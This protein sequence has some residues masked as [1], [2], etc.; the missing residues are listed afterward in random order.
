MLVGKDTFVMGSEPS[1]DLTADIVEKSIRLIVLYCWMWFRK[2]CLIRYLSGK[3]RC[4][5]LVVQ[6]PMKLM[7]TN[8]K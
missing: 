7:E 3:N 5:Q 6:N 1:P 8:M 4:L 2:N